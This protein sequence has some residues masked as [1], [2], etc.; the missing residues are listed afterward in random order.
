M[1]SNNTKG[2]LIEFRKWLDLIQVDNDT[3][4]IHALIERLD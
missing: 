3:V 4:N 1:E 2:E